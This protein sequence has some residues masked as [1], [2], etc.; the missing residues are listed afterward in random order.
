MNKKGFTLIELLATVIILSLVIVIVAT[1]GFGAF[2]LTKDKI[3]EQ[4]K[5]TI[6]EA[7]RVFIVDVNNCEYDN[8]LEELNNVLS[9]NYASCSVLNA[10]LKK[11]SVSFLVDNNYLSGSNIEK[12]TDLYVNINIEENIANCCYNS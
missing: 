9:K 12:Y 10:D 8:S 6:E 3:D 1:N 2:D 4:D 7:A 11:I 5:R